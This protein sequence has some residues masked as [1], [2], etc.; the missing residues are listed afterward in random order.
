MH[1]TVHWSKTDKLY[2]GVASNNFKERK[3]GHDS[4]VNTGKLRTSLTKYLVELNE[5]NVRYGIKW[6]LVKTG[7]PFFNRSNED[8]QL[9]YFEKLYILLGPKNMMNSRE[10]LMLQCLHGIFQRLSN[11]GDKVDRR[12]G[13]P[14]D[15]N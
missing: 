14:P 2:Y 11:V 10:E 7:I 5:N 6:S 1:F 15:I 12:R 13:P 3:R 4:D 8:C 9:C